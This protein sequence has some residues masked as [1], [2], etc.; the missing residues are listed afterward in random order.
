[1][2]IVERVYI[3]RTLSKTIT[4]AYANRA[5]HRRKRKGVEFTYQTNPEKGRSGKHKKNYAGDPSNW[6]TGDKTCL[7]HGPGN[8]AEGCKLLKEYSE[9]YAVQRPHK[10]KEARS[11]GSKKIGNN[12]KFNGE[13]QEVNTMVSHDV[14]I[15]RKKKG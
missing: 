5:S 13:T 9:K 12:V 6:T 7:V 15:P 2:E 8:S 11:R 4:R 14:T 3:G 10:E 1:M